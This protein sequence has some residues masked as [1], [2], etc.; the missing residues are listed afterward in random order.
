M[1]NFMKNFDW[2]MH[3]FDTE[4]NDD[5]QMNSDADFKKKNA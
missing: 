2:Y 5:E 4:I 1:E 3:N